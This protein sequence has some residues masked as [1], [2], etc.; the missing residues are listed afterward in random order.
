M[1]TTKQHP[2]GRRV[3]IQNKDGFQ[4]YDENSLRYENENVYTSKGVYLGK[5]KS[6]EN[7]NKVIFI[8]DMNDK[9]GI[10]LSSLD[11]DFI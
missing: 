10:K 2:N 9:D 4:C 3:L 1:N 7:I 5:I 6:V 11:D 8:K